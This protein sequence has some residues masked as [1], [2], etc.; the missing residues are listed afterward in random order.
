MRRTRADVASARPEAPSPRMDAAAW[1]AAGGGAPTLSQHPIPSSVLF[2][3]FLDVAVQGRRLREFILWGSQSAHDPLA[4]EAFARQ[5]AADEGIRSR[6]PMEQHLAHRLRQQARGGVRGAARAP[7]GGPPAAP[8]GSRAG[9]PQGPASPCSGLLRGR[10][11]SSP[12]AN[13][14]PLSL[15]LPSG[16]HLRGHRP[17]GPPAALGAARRAAQSTHA[18]WPGGV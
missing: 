14:T 15:A 4:L 2:P 1:P 9:R 7:A 13:P 6:A 16:G 10:P 17:A 8:A 12:L 11:P 18:R 5:L 3:L